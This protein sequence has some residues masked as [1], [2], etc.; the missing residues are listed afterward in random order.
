MWKPFTTVLV[1]PSILKWSDTCVDEN[2]ADRV[3]WGLLIEK[4]SLQQGWF[5][6]KS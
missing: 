3:L 1:P 2:L 6:R 5:W 4:D